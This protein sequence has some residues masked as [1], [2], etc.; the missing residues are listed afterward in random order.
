M[1][2]SFVRKVREAAG[3]LQREFAER[4]GVKRLQVIRWESGKATP[5]GDVRDR[6]RAIGRAVG[7]VEESEG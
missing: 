2:G 4:V 6:I 3:L 5:V 7:V 1:T